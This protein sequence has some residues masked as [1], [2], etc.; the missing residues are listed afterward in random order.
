MYFQRPP[1]QR[2]RH[3]GIGQHTWISGAPCVMDP[4][5]APISNP[6]VH[7]LCYETALAIFTWSPFSCTNSGPQFI[8][9]LL[10]FFPPPLHICWPLFPSL[11]SPYS[12]PLPQIQAPRLFACSASPIHTPRLPACP[13]SLISPAQSPVPAHWYCRCLNEP[14]MRCIH[15]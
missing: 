3:L 8:T 9:L 14:W 13:V 1:N 12:L 10:S 6:P 15:G 2:D 5:I 4:L 7:T 11:S